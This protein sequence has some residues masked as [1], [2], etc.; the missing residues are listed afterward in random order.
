MKQLHSQAHWY[1]LDKAK[2]THVS[3][4]LF[5]KT[6]F[7]RAGVE[8][9]TTHI[10]RSGDPAQPSFSHNLKIHRYSEHIYTKTW[11]H[12]R[13]L[14]S[15]WGCDNAFRQVSTRS[16]RAN[17]HLMSRTQN[18]I[19]AVARYLFL[20]CLVV[21]ADSA[22]LKFDVLLTI[23]K[24]LRICYTA[25]DSR[26][27]CLPKPMQHSKVNHQI[28]IWKENNSLTSRNSHMMISLT[29]QVFI[30]IQSWQPWIARQNIA[31]VY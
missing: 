11:N 23:Y 21:C 17:S 16:I 1:H 31:S 7:A 18:H 12:E 5:D 10:L 22:M 9:W 28:G 3:A 20:K 14:T 27:L 29:N 2:R 25:Y 15:A 24:T 6:T 26:A 8:L 4:T 13:M 19:W 30:Q